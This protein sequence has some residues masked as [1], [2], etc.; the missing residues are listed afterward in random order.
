MEANPKASWKKTEVGEEGEKAAASQT[1][2][3]APLALVQR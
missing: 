2:R 3:Q 1:G